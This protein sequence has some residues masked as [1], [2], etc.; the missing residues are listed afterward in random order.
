MIKIQ[1][2]PWSFLF[3]ILTIGMWVG[4][5]AGRICMF[6]TTRPAVDGFE[7]QNPQPA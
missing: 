1:E 2:G 7:N 3:K 6:P 4:V 5:G